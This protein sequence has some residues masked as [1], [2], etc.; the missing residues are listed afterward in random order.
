M[1]RHGPTQSSVKK[2]APL[3]KII[4]TTYITPVPGVHLD[5]DKLECGHTIL[6]PTDRNGA[7]TSAIRRRCRFCAV[8]V[9]R[10]HPEGTT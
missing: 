7:V 9:A 10:Y 2:N 3:R 5:A 6:A 8:H 1:T 4:G